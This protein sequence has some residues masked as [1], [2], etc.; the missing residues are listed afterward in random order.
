MAWLSH[1][2]DSVWGNR[3]DQEPEYH[4]PYKLCQV[5]DLL[6]ELQTLVEFKGCRD[7]I[8]IS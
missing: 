3:G 5:F 4:G 2:K 8:C 1:E 6:E 7:I